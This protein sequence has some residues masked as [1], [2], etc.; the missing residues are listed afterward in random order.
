MS[1]FQAMAP[2]GYAAGL[3]LALMCIVAFLS[4]ILVEMLR[5]IDSDSDG[6]IS[7]EEWIQGGLHTI[8]LLVLLG[9]ETVSAFPSLSIVQTGKRASVLPPFL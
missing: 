2:T 9:L 7:L 4:Q 5:D 6:R 1:K 3:D 8:P